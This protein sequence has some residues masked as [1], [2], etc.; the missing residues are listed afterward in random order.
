MRWLVRFKLLAE[1]MKSLITVVI[2]F[3][4]AILVITWASLLI[5]DRGTGDR[6]RTIRTGLFTSELQTKTDAYVQACQLQ[7]QLAGKLLDHLGNVTKTLA[8]AYADA[9][10]AGK[11]NADDI[12]NKMDFH[13]NTMIAIVA[14]NS[15]MIGIID[16]SQKVENLNASAESMNKAFGNTIR[17]DVI[18]N[19][20][21]SQSPVKFTLCDNIPQH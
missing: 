4:L 8:Q 6:T 15:T 19:R 11:A 16:S 3:A 1:S 10:L 9:S 2:A 14:S 7:T 5:F 12:G 13:V 21:I 17:K 18:L 20:I